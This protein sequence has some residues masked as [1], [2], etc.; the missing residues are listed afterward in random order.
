MLKTDIK[1]P[2]PHTLQFYQHYGPKKN[3]YSHERS[4]ESSGLT[5]MIDTT[6]PTA[7]GKLRPYVHLDGSAGHGADTQYL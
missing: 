2:K 3:R 4:C 7:L 6:L 5:G 1:V